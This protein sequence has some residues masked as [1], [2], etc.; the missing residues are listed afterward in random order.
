MEN[1]SNISKEDLSRKVSS[2]LSRQFVTRKKGERR[3]GEGGYNPYR[4]RR[5]KE[6]VY[7]EAG[8]Y[9][10]SASYYAYIRACEMD[11]WGM[12]RCLV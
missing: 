4:D 5:R 9:I 3:G 8:V 6:E 1:A 10:L 2:H 12:I 11:G 7:R